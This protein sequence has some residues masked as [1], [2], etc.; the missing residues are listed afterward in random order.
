MGVRIGIQHKML[1]LTLLSV[2]F[3][4]IACGGQQSKPDSAKAPETAPLGKAY[5]NILCHKFE[6]TPE[7]Q[8]DYPEAVAELQHSAMA[9]LQMKNKFN[10]IE[11]AKPGQSAGDDTLL[12]KA[13]ITS[14]RIVSRSARLWGGPFV[15]SSGI[16][17]NL[18]L[19][20]GATNTVVRE[21]KLDS[22]NNAWGAAYTA[23]STDNSLA[24]DMGK[25]LAEYVAAA[26]SMPAK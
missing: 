2:T 25:I 6:C 23:G 12:V 22:H 13:D 9:G 16:E 26:A 3:S 11:M 8:K 4:I 24:S 14:L 10:R 15:G 7:I 20:D 1:W 18:Q 19:I 21:E 5:R 17:L